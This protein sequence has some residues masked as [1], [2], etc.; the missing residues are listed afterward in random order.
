MDLRQLTLLSSLLRILLS[1]IIGGILGMER[2]AKNRPAGFRTYILVASGACL[3]M[4]TNQYAFQTF[5]TSD[6]VR[7]GAQ[8][9]SGIGFLGAGTIIVTGRNRVTG[10]TTAAGLWTSACC[11]LAIGIGFYEGAVLGGL[12]I[13]MVMHF[14]Q[15][16]DMVI[17]NHSKNAY[18]YVEYDAHLPFS[19]FIE[20]M[21]A[22]GVDI[23][24]VQMQ[25]NAM[26]DEGR[27]DI[28]F[29]AHT[30]PDMVRGEMLDLMSVAPGVLFLEEV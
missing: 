1:V 25:K 5:S 15:R 17:R 6:P 11:G 9:I 7:M 12:T 13:F 24:E 22:K 27:I 20:Q 21:R 29:R 2:G 8:V 10:V 26:S 28:L 14:L 23:T 4:M 3:V 18:L 30:A 19:Q 16:F